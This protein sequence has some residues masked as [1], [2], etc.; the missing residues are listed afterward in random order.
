METKFLNIHQLE[1]L[2]KKGFDMFKMK[3]FDTD[4]IGY[5][6]FT[7]V[8]EVSFPDKDVTEFSGLEI[9][10]TASEIMRKTMGTDEATKN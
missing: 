7:A 6:F 1:S 8:F 10:K 2:R 5:D 3:S 4:E 9:I